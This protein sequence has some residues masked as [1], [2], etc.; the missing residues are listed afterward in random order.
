M[1]SGKITMMSGI[2][3]KKIRIGCQA[4]GYDDWISR[5]GQPIF[6]PQGT[7]DADK[8]ALYAEIFDLIELDSTVYAIPPLSN[9]ETWCRKT[10]ADFIFAPKLPNQITHK[11]SLRPVTWPILEEFSERV[12]HFGHK[13]GPILALLPNHFDASPENARNLRHFLERLPP[14]LRFA[15]E[16]RHP[17]W[18]T[19]STLKMLAEHGAA[20]GMAEGRWIPREAYFS[21]MEHPTADFAYIRFSGPR[22]LVKFDR[23]YRDMD[24]NLLEWAEEIKKS[25]AREIFIFISNFYEGHAP[26]SVNKLKRMLGLEITEPASLEKQPS[27]FNS[28]FPSRR[29]KDPNLLLTLCVS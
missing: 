11:N 6:Y 23:V 15:F 27:L 10:P 18:L 24:A 21:R 26:A 14:D 5:P 20:L 17:D 29:G 16:F 12:R 1:S 28:L 22:D 2:P 9:I 8:L 7:Q 19:G 13:L 25:P 3:E 4:W